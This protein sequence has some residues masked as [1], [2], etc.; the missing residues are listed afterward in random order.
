M[1]FK[2]NEPSEETKRQ[3][4]LFFLARSVPRILADLERK[5]KEDRQKKEVGYD[6]IKTADHNIAWSKQR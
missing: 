2:I 5:E 6:S 4:Q 1:G 3:M